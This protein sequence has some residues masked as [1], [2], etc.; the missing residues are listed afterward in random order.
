MRRTLLLGTSFLLVF[1]C[2]VL[3]EWPLSQAHEMNMQLS[4]P[5]AFV[6][7]HQALHDDLLN[8]LDPARRVSGTPEQ[9][10]PWVVVR[11]CLVPALGLT[12]LGLPAAA[13]AAQ[14]L[15]LG[16]WGTYENPVA[17]PLALAEQ[18]PFDW[19]YIAC[20]PG[21]ILL[22]ITITILILRGQTYRVLWLM[23]V[24]GW[25]VVTSFA[26]WLFALFGNLS[27]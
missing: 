18:L 24:V 19:R 9:L 1:G 14:H 23:P 22:M 25:I 4:S 15:V 2:C 7:P 16:T 11:G 6:P 10:H 3:S 27:Q 21:F 13:E 5:L 12:T 20:R 8:K 26:A 17:T